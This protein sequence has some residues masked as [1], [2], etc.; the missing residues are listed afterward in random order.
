MNDVVTIR[1]F[2]KGLKNADSLATHIYEKGPQRLSNAISKV[3][4]LNAV[5]QLTA[6]IIPPSTVNMMSNDEDRCFQCQEQ[7][8]IARNC[9]DIRCFKCD[10]YG[11]IVMDCPH[12][13][14]PLGTP[15]KHHQP[16]L[17]RS[18]PMSG[19]VQDTTVKTGTGKVVPGHNHIFTDITAQVIMTHIQATPG[20]DTG[21]T[22]TT[23]EVAYDVHAPHIEI[24][25]ID[26]AMTH[27]TNPTADHPHTEVP[28]PTTPEIEVDPI[29]ICPTNPPGEICTGHTHIPA[30]HEPNHTTRR[31]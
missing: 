30:D 29:Q 14:P 6:T 31:T 10:E 11:H 17:H 1:I 15:A 8:H 3:E 28:Q 20:H 2:I 16:R 22:A 13:I 4:K 19:Q 27:H 21:I 26:L 9:P 25:A 24:K 5:Q 7:G 12:R 18:H 23:P